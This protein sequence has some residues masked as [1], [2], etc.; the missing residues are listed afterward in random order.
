MVTLR[1]VGLMW[2]MHGSKTN[3]SIGACV[4]DHGMRQRFSFRLRKYDTAFQA[5]VYAIK[6]CIDGNIRRSYCNRNIYILSDSEAAIN[7]FDNC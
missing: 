2:F 1:K 7:A 5:K 3:E 4:Y 6:A